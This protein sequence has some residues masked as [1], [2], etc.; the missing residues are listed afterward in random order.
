MN[1]KGEEDFVEISIGEVY[2]QVIMA[3][4]FGRW[5][6]LLDFSLKRKSL[7]KYKKICQRINQTNFIC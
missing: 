5:S 2:F 4:I 7:E 3:L 6:E 1:F